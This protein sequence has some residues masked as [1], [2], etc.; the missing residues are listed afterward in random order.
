MTEEITELAMLQFT[1]EQI[2]TILDVSEIDDQAYQRGLLLAEAE[3][4]KSI[5]TMAKQGSSP[6]QK[7]YLQL[8]KNRQENESF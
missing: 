1:K 7:E 5:L 4:R 6:A 2:C 8:I 3:V